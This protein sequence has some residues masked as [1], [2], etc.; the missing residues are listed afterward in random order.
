[1]G[2]VPATHSRSSSP[3]LST[4]STPLRDLASPPVLSPEQSTMAPDSKKRKL[5]FVER[6]VEKAVKRRV[7]E[8]KEKQRAEA[9]AQKDQEK[10]RRDE[11]KE[12]ARRIKEERKRVKDAE[13]QEK[14]ADKARKVAE[15]LK[16]ERV[17]LLAIPSLQFC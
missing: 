6:E 17:R 1:M 2:E 11:E 5:T 9:K 14:E 8:E 15:A 4:A 3:A 10:K 7:K 12:A 16:K 13:K